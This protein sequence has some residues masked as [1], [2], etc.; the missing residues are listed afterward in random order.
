MKAFLMRLALLVIVSSALGLVV[1]GLGGNYLPVAFADEGDLDYCVD[2]DPWCAEC[3][4]CY[5]SKGEPTG[6]IWCQRFVGWIPATGAC[7]GAR[8][9]PDITCHDP[10]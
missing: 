4:P 6:Q 1:G 7:C 2:A 9:F 5:N 8:I 10:N 3:Y